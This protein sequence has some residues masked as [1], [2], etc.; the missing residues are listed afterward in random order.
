MPQVTVNVVSP[1]D[2]S[3]F[4]GASGSGMQQADLRENARQ[5]DQA[6]QQ[7]GEQFQQKM[8]QDQQQFER[9]AGQQDQQIALSK[10]QLALQQKMAEHNKQM[11]LLEA[12]LMAGRE[13]V[14]NRRT[15]IHDEMTNAIMANNLDLLE[16]LYPQLDE[17]SKEADDNDHKTTKLSLLSKYQDAAVNGDTDEKTG[18][19]RRP[20]IE[21]DLSQALQLHLQNEH[22]RESDLATALSQAVTAHTSGAPTA[23]GPI[24][25]RDPQ[26]ALKMSKKLE[27]KPLPMPPSMRGADL[28]VFG[29]GEV[30]K[31]VTGGSQEEIVPHT[32]QEPEGTAG[33][34]TDDLVMRTAPQLGL[35]GEETVRFRQ[36][37]QKLE[38][39]AHMNSLGM[40]ESRDAALAEAQTLA[41]GLVAEGVEAGKV[42]FLLNGLMKE[43]AEGRLRM[44][45]ASSQVAKDEAGQTGK[46]PYNV[47]D[48]NDAA[49]FSKVEQMGVL[50]MTMR[51]EDGKVL[52]KMGAP[53][54][55]DEK[56]GQL[57]RTG[58]DMRGLLE[59]ATADFI[60]NGKF[61]QRE[62]YLTGLPPALRQK[63]EDALVAREK[64]WKNQLALEGLPEGTNVREELEGARKKGQSLKSKKAALENEATVGGRRNAIEGSKKASKE[65][66]TAED[67]LLGPMYDK[68]NGLLSLTQ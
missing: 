49:Y 13:R 59:E 11:Q 55:K 31:A 66:R 29:A 23:K 46:M 41:Q 68:L 28:D 42:S 65:T 61:D 7:Q 57:T 6:Q 9:G 52:F 14:E 12:A 36:M 38:N 10:D 43:G 20:L 1:G 45:G 30:V 24:D 39:A 17:V 22:Q 60:D 58:I 8:G 44:K 56:T 27:G 2:G 67:E 19:T 18:A 4:P 16:K 50:G 54:G 63:V 35:S 47:G 64:N 3:Q 37:V 26:W 40:S 53:I 34:F 33:T 32:S 48:P 25:G 5:F 62:K 15:Q 21:D 51:G